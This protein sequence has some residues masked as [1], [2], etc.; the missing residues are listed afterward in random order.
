M[1]KVN[2]STF[3]CKYEIITKFIYTGKQIQNTFLSKYKTL[4]AVL[5]LSLKGKKY[6][7]VTDNSCAILVI[8]GKIAFVGY[9][10]GKT[11]DDYETAVRFCLH[12]VGILGCKK[13]FLPVDVSLFFQHRVV[14]EKNQLCFFQQPESQL[15]YGDILKKCGCSVSSEYFSAIRDDWKYILDKPDLLKNTPSNKITF[16]ILSP[17]ITDVLLI[18]KI[19]RI[20]Q[21]LFKNHIGFSKITFPTF[22]LYKILTKN[23]KI[24]PIQEVITININNK[25][26]GFAV[27]YIQTIDF[28]KIIIIKTIAVL[29]DFQRKGL[30]KLLS[31]TLHRIATKRDC[32]GVIYATILDGNIVSKMNTNNL[33][34]IGRYS[35]YTKLIL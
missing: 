23:T 6:F 8:F 18:Y 13:V 25:F 15:F 26:A 27:F 34:I 20:S 1:K 9:L 29:P 19:F 5:F 12:Q 21:D 31:K 24:D 16:R 22:L 7:F 11:P 3:K 2:L 14:S 17:K 33:E 35:I 4:N 30:S 10:E 32:T 28:K